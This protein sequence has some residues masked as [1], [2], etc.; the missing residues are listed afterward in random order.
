MGAAYLVCGLALFYANTLIG[1]LAWAL[2]DGEDGDIGRWFDN[3]PKEIAWFAQPIVLTVWPIA[4][5]V[6]WTR[7][8]HP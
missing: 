4:I 1:C 7:R 8:T 5:W 3:C 2:V 6:Y